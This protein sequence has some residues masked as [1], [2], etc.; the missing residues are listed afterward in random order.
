MLAIKIFPNKIIAQSE[1]NDQLIPGE[2]NW[3]EAM[4]YGIYSGSSELI[5]YAQKMM[6]YIADIIHFV[7]GTHSVSGFRRKVCA[8]SNNSWFNTGFH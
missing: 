6:V 3:N 4:I 1:S 5:M 2:A 7:D 8:E